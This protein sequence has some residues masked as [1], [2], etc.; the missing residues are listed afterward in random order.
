MRVL[1]F[2]LT[3]VLACAPAAD[4]QV[5]RI[6]GT[7]KTDHGE[8]VKG[9][10]VTARSSVVQ[11]N[12]FR[13]STNEQGEWS[14]LGL[15][16]G[17]WSLEVVADGFETARNNVRVSSFDRN[18][19]FDIILAP[20]RVGAA[21]GRLDAATLQAALKEA[22]D[23]ADAKRWAEAIDAYRAILQVAPAL[24]TVYLPLGRAC[25]EAGRSD[26]A[27]AAFKSHLA[28]HARSQIALV[29]LGRTYL[30]AGDRTS[31]VAAW[32]EAVDV[33]PSTAQ[34]ASARALL[35]QVKR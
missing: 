30:A 29:E 6:R 2:V 23:H 18:R 9:A 20:L 14:M 10:V 19:S 17:V 24:T 27:V 4:A 22:D 15:R 32:T 5:A 11:P 26:E 35:E 3:L 28:I 8:P 33:D 25:R 34:A 1:P 7:V 16:S 12:E 31:A 21:A 13:S